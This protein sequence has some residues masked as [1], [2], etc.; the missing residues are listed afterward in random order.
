MLLFSVLDQI[1]N[2]MSQ[3]SKK[4][5]KLFLVQFNDLAIELENE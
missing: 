4:I 1:N 2:T 5:K 3:I